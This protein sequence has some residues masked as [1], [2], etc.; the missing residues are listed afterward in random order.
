[1]S[2][3]ACVYRS[4]ALFPLEPTIDA[5]TRRRLAFLV[6]N[7]CPVLF[8][9]VAA[10][11]SD[12]DARCL[13]RRNRHAFAK[14]CAEDQRLIPARHHPTPFMPDPP[15]MATPLHRL[16][17]KLPADLPRPPTQSLYFSSSILIRHSHS[18]EPIHLTHNRP[19]SGQYISGSTSGRTA[20]PAIKAVHFSLGRG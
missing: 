5:A 20:I 13:G 10:G 6:N 18:M 16:D 4:S 14:P 15:R 19:P 3:L 8:T 1:M 2:S 11:R 12:H 7:S 17:S 9:D